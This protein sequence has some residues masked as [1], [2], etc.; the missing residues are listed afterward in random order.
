MP[1]RN[2]F[3][4]ET[5][6]SDLIA[7]VVVFLVALPLCLGVA[8]AS[9]APLFS[10]VLAGIIGGIVVGTISKSHT[11]VSGP[12]AGLA[13]VV[14]A[15]IVS[16][17][18]ESFLAAVVI[19]GAIQ[20]GLGI[21]KAGFIADF[22]PTSVIT[23]LLAAIG[24][25]LILKQIPHV[26]GH[27]PDPEGNM[28]FLQSDERNTF[29]EIAALLDHFNLGATIIGI[30]SLA[31]LVAWEKIKW[32]KKSPV[33]GPLV[34]VLFGIAMVEWL[35]HWGGEWPIEPSHLVNVPVMNS[36]EDAI[37]F[38]TLPKPSAW[39]SAAT[40]RAGVTLAIVASLETLLN[41]E[42]VDKLDPRAR[43]SP[44]NRELVAQGIGN[45]VAGMIGA[46]PITS[47]IVRS[48]V[49]INAGGRTRVAAIFHG[50]LLLGCVALLPTWLNSIPLSA[51]AAIL[52]VTGFKLAG[53]EVFLAM[54]SKGRNQF[55]P[56]AITVSA[57]VLTDLLVGVLI[58][59]GVAVAF[60]LWS[61]VRRPLHRIVEKHM[62]GEVLHLHL[63]NQVSFLNRAAIVRVLEEVPP[64]GH[65]LIDAQET[66]YIDPDVLDLIHG[67]EKKMAPSRGVK[68]SLQGFADRY[69]MIDRIQFVDYTTRE[70]QRSLSP[71]QVLRILK[72]GHERFL[73]GQRLRRNLTRQVDATANGQFPFAVVLSCIDS[74][75]PA[76]LIFDVGVGDIF[77]VRIAGNVATEKELGS[78]E[79]ACAVAGA[80]LI[81]VLGH[82]KC[83]AVTAAIDLA[84]SKTSAAEATGCTNLDSLIGEIQKSIGCHASPKNAEEKQTL[85]EETCTRNILRTIGTIHQFSPALLALERDGRIAIAGAKYDVTTGRIDFLSDLPEHVAG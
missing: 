44:P 77:S 59:L 65:I 55:L 7:G 56:F 12:A 18:F 2:Y 14:S 78:M 31:L 69:H 80:K 13:A 49:N 6:P 79:Y 11:S 63:A 61:N 60:I 17:G 62:G 26:A 30:G 5:L 74:R 10:G 57:I 75:S 76:E 70:M 43:T 81:L 73:T 39:L 85:I 40:W 32:L 82:T 66:D 19:A 4:R 37:G 23:G 20:I 71:A 1:G 9:K 72:D 68:V 16:L 54:W 33:P 52:L 35:R 28:A 51:L 45:V 46:I 29:T 3:S 48:S 15:Q 36:L 53:P 8:L 64:G 58:G 83:G 25:I 22:F 50:L 34:V 47:V 21:A 38:L 27:D 67:F 42:A 41:L 84:I 24:I